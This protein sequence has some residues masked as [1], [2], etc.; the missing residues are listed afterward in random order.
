MPDLN[1]ELYEEC[2]F[3]K[4][5][6]YY[7]TCIKSH[8]LSSLDQLLHA[9]IKD[10]SDSCC[11]L[12]TII[13]GHCTYNTQA[14]RTSYCYAYFNFL[15]SFIVQSSNE[16]IQGIDFYDHFGGYIVWDAI[17]DFLFLESFLDSETKLMHY[18]GSFYLQ[19]LMASL[20]SSE[21]WYIMW[22]TCPDLASF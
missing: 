12:G 7:S 3:Q 6:Y 21:S 14:N 8:E 22:S 19:H 4:S 17:D 10:P 2:S 20:E 5:H 13:C 18:F 15:C 9:K 16:E 11:S 1:L